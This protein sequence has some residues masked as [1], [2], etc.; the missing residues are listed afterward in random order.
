M[1]LRNQVASFYSIA[2]NG[3]YYMHFNALYAVLRGHLFTFYYSEP[4]S[5]I[6]GFPWRLISHL[7]HMNAIF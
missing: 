7:G 4:E 1:S 2:D 6:P 5:I 3:P